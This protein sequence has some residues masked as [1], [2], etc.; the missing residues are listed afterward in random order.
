M[1]HVPLGVLA[2]AVLAATWDAEAIGAAW[3]SLLLA[4]GCFFVAQGALFSALRR[5]EASTVAP[6]LSVKIAT[7]AAASWAV[8]GVAVTPLGFLA[9]GLA[10]GG[11]A[12]VGGVGERPDARSLGLIFLAIAGY[13]G[14]DMGIV[15]TIE[16]MLAAT[17]PDGTG[18]GDRL[19]A[20]MRAAGVLYSGFGLVALALLPG[21]LRRRA[22]RPRWGGA[23]AY[24]AC[25]ALAMA[26]LFSAFSLLSVVL[27][28][29]LQ[30]TRSLWSV[31]LGGLLGR[32]GLGHLE[33]NH[34]NGALAVR[35]LGAAAL[36]LA[37]GLYAWGGSAPPAGAG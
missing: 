24:A 18:G 33:T 37:V 11:A 20:A 21:V 16:R 6:L 36:V 30:S 15:R 28:V 27:V 29:I 7:L 26:T 2:A 9:I 1:A 3:P 32:L 25:W 34:S 14:C 12:V 22:A 10:V 8:Q 31:L 19:R 35:L 13:T 4:F 17:G 5:V 23:L